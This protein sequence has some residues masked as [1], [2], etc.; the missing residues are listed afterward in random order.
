M[1][2]VPLLF[3]DEEFF[4]TRH[5]LFEEHFGRNLMGPDDFFKDME[6]FRKNHCPYFK[7]CNK[8]DCKCNGDSGDVVMDKDKF[9]VSLDVKQFKPEEITVKVT[10]ENTLT[11]EGKHEE[12]QDG[13]GYIS[14]N[15]VR[16]FVISKDHDMEKIV[17]KMSS[18]G[19]LTITAPKIDINALEDK[20]IP[21]TQTGKKF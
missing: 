11:V 14:R 2:V 6:Q 15:F 12:K 16:R 4:K 18:D 8:T 17:S 1:S 9:Q 21:I 19:V 3:D 5:H 7:Q 13:H 10:D 20:T